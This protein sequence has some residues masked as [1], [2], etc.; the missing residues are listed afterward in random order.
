MKCVLILAALLCLSL[1][2]QA[3]T[4]TTRGIVG[5][6][7]CVQWQ[8]ELPNGGCLLSATLRLSNPT[9]W[10]PLQARVGNDTLRLERRNDSLWLVGG[11]IAPDGE[12]TLELCGVVLAGSDS[13]CI[14]TLDSVQGCDINLMRRV[15]VVVVRSIGPPLPYVRFA[16]L[17]GPYPHPIE[18]DEPFVIY[19]G[20]DIRSEVWIRLFDLLGR[21]VLEA[22]QQQERGVYR[23]VLQLPLGSAPGLY[24]LRLD[25]TSGS[26][27]AVVVVD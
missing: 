1:P 17:E 22:K 8:I 2:A 6:T 23:I 21:Q 9:V 18:R 4:D 10:Y 24:L 13:V 12:H 26:D 5:R 19:I 16:R 7:L 25:T 3:Q 27:S 14:V 20:L 15:Q 11:M